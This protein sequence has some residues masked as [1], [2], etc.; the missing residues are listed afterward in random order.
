MKDCFSSHSEAMDTTI[1]YF[2]HAC[3]EHTCVEHA[4]YGFILTN[5]CHVSVPVNKQVV[6]DWVAQTY[7]SQKLHF[8]ASVCLFVFVVKFKHSNICRNK[9]LGVKEAEEREAGNI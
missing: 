1:C 3:V 6:Y 5:M 7:F 9:Y 4:G 2:I 8:L